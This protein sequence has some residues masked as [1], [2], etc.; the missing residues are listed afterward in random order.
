MLSMKQNKKPKEKPTKVFLF[1]PP[2]AFNLSLMLFFRG[3]QLTR[4]IPGSLVTTSEAKFT[5]RVKP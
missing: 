2:L 5:S 3:K 4:S 1:L